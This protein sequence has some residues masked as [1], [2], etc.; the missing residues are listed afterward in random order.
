MS[1]LIFVALGS[2][3]SHEG[4]RTSD[5]SPKEGFP[6][7]DTFPPYPLEVVSA[8]NRSDGVVIEW[9]VPG[10]RASNIIRVERFGVYRREGRDDDWVEIGRLPGTNECPD[11]YRYFDATAGSGHTYFYGVSIVGRIQGNKEGPESEITESAGVF[12][13]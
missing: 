2:P 12:V 6:D 4:T 1:L 11:I 10:C 8:R 5:P 13:P 7:Y 9:Q 3:L